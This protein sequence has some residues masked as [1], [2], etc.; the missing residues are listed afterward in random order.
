MAQDRLLLEPEKRVSGQR[1][2]WRK[3]PLQSC[4]TSSAYLWPSQCPR[5]PQSAGPASPGLV[6]LPQV[7][8]RARQCGQSIP[9]ISL[10]ISPSPSHRAERLQKTERCF[11]QGHSKNNAHC[12]LR[13]SSHPG[14]LI[15]SSMLGPSSYPWSVARSPINPCQSLQRSHQDSH[16]LFGMAESP[17]QVLQSY[18]HHRPADR[19]LCFQVGALGTQHWFEGHSHSTQPLELEPWLGTESQESHTLESSEPRTRAQTEILA[20]FPYQRLAH[21]WSVQMPAISTKSYQPCAPTFQAALHTHPR[22]NL[23]TAYSLSACF[24]PL[25]LLSPSLSA[26][27][28]LALWQPPTPV[29]HFLSLW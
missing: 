2:E 24:L 20:Q 5:E 29:M 14:T 7:P 13:T 16:S 4:S 8:R 21:R 17:G 25:C 6:G 15:S 28:L 27:S 1:A 9:G 23:H 18:L 11:K 19:S 3:V 12:N 10:C 22:R 26:F